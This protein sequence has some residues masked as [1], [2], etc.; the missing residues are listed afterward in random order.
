MQYRT[1]FVGKVLRVQTS[2]LQRH[3]LIL[4]DALRASSYSNR[5]IDAVHHERYLARYSPHEIPQK[6]HT[7]Q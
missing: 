7:E 6:K 5:S 4:L 2:R 1:T 3:F